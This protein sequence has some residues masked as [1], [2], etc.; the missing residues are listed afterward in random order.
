MKSLYEFSVAGADA[1]VG[2]LI[3]SHSQHC[4]PGIV[5]AKCGDAAVSRGLWRTTWQCDDHSLLDPP[6][7]VDT[8]PKTLRSEEYWKHFVPHLN[9]NGEYAFPGT[10][11]G[12]NEVSLPEKAALSVISA[13]HLRIAQPIITAG[14]AV[15]FRA[16]VAQQAALD[17]SATLGRVVL[18]SNK[19]SGD[20]FVFE[21]PLAMAWTDAEHQSYAVSHCDECG[22]TFKKR[23]GTYRMKAYRT[24]LRGDSPRIIQC[25]END[26]IVINEAMKQR[27]EKCDE[28]I[29]F[30]KCGEC[31]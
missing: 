3:L 20:Y 21:S 12:S 29:A 22:T 17:S 14:S 2:H 30:R 23:G 18:K 31:E 15:L 5:C 7:R 13:R 19:A 26:A 11:I 8:S 9:T 10:Y 24:C 28:R 4:L 27:F 16:D 25:L 1:D 6:S